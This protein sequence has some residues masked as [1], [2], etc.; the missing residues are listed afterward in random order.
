MSS[1]SLEHPSSARVN[2]RPWVR[3]HAVTRGGS[4]PSAS[5]WS[6]ARSTG[7]GT[8]TAH[9]ISGQALARLHRAYPRAG[10]RPGH[11]VSRGHGAVSWFARAPAA[12][13][14]SLCS[15][16]PAD[17][18]THRGW[19]G[20]AQ[21]GPRPDAPPSTTRESGP[22]RGLLTAGV[23]PCARRNCPRRHGAAPQGPHPPGRTSS[24]AVGAPR[25]FRRAR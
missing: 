20:D 12:P 23:V 18:I 5:R 9:G 17:G 16:I 11:L 7:A 3:A 15:G 22:G 2:E 10:P 24:G 13:V 19:R 25:R 4:A 6:R 1:L 8:A 21:R 14:G